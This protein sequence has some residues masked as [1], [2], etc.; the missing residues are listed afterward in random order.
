MI[1][2][3]ELSC[4]RPSKYDE[5][6]IQATDGL[7]DVMSTDSAALYA[8]EQLVNERLIGDRRDDLSCQEVKLRLNNICNRMAINAVSNLHSMDNVTVSIILISC[9]GN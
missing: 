6:I 5:F 9:T 8:R 3:P 2:D 1:P 7:W 4:F